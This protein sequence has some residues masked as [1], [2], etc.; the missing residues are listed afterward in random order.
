MSYEKK[1]R[2]MMDRLAAMSPE[3]PPY[4]EEMTTARPGARRSRRP[5]LAF[6]T[7]AALVA[8]L[9]IPLLLFTGEG[10]PIGADSTTTTVTTTIATTS[11]TASGETT[12]TQATTTTTSPTAAPVEV[13]GVVFLYQTPENSFTGNPS[14]VPIAVTVQVF[15]VAD[16]DVDFATAWRWV[17][18]G[19]EGLPNGLENAIPVNV[20]VE[21]TTVE[22]G[23]IVA[24]MSDAFVNGGSPTGLLADITMLNQLVYNL[25]WMAEDASVLFTVDS[26]PV[27][28]FGSEGLDLTDPVDRDDFL[29]HLHVINLTSPV[30]L[31]DDERYLVEGIAN[32]FEASVTIAVIDGTGD[33]V[34]E[35]FVSATCGSGCWGE[36]SASIASDLVVPGE[37]SIRVFQYSAEDGS[38]VDAITVPIPPEG[39]WRF[40]VGG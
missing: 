16:Q 10:E 13:S 27:S 7:A 20:T 8:I 4:P 24:E 40:T 38:V 28:A 9:A 11:T 32:V 19:R 2:E 5:A 35:Q 14:M 36:F 26:Q 25:T 12:T 6:A 22:N 33:V 1:I 29:D 23:V 37:S 31:Q 17:G 39:V 34:D 30:V 3:P 15:G 18:E 21:G